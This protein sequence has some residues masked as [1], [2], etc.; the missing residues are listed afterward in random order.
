MHYTYFFSLFN[1]KKNKK[2]IKVTSSRWNQ[3]YVYSIK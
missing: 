2:K 1:Q 3:V